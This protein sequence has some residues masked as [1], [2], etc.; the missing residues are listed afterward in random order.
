M[1]SVEINYLWVGY[2]RRPRRHNLVAHANPLEASSVGN[3][4]ELVCL[5]ASIPQLNTTSMCVLT[6]WK[7]LNPEVVVFWTGTPGA[8][9]CNKEGAIEKQDHI[10][11]PL[12]R[13]ERA[14]D[15]GD[16]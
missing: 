12:A 10:R 4:V 2:R 8:P 6:E 3:V 7:S 5:I 16:G 11:I 13:Q 15:W 9:R 1:F 14:R